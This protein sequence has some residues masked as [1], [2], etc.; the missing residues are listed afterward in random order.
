MKG[1]TCIGKSRKL[2]QDMWVLFKVLQGV[3]DVASRLALPQHCQRFIP[4]NMFLNSKEHTR[5][6][7]YLVV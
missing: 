2:V 1:L 6:R 5:S 7:S 4:Y 3:G